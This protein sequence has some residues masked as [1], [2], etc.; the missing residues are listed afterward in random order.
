MKTFFLIISCILFT[1]LV[2]AQILVGQNPHGSTISLITTSSSQLSDSLDVNN[3]GTYDLLFIASTQISIDSYG[4][5]SVQSLDSTIEFAASQ[6]GLA[7]RFN[8]NDLISD[9]LIWQSEPQVFRT[10][11]NAFVFNGNGNWRDITLSATSGDPHPMD[12]YLGFRLKLS[13]DTLYGWVHV[14][15]QVAG[16]FLA[17]LTVSSYGIENMTSVISIRENDEIKEIYPTVSE[18]ELHMVNIKN[19][20]CIAEIY[21]SEGVLLSSEKVENNI[22]N[23]SALKSGIFYLSIISDNKRYQFKFI[24]VN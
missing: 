24:K 21:S 1:T 2:N 9:Q 16:N 11:M 23:V 14:V 8:N 15:S 17:S 6:N 22:L 19:L 20:P 3:D 10:I 5:T 4:I 12:G 7:D 18:S 13:S